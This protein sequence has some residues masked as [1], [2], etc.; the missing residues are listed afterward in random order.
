MPRLSGCLFKFI[1]KLPPEVFIPSAGVKKLKRCSKK[2]LTK[3]A[4]KTPALE[5]LF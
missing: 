1:Q 2:F 3:F 5:S 4:R